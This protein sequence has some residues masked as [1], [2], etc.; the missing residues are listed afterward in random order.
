M[1]REAWLAEGV[2]RGIITEGQRSALEALAAGDRSPDVAGA[3]RASLSPM[4]ATGVMIAY[5]VGAMLALFA[6]GWFV[7]DRWEALGG[8]GLL[9]VATGY[10]LLFLGVARVLAREGYPL[11]HDLAVFLAVAITPLL[12][13]AL[14]VVLGLW[15]DAALR[16]CS[17]LM[18]PAAPCA[19]TPIAL[20]LLT[21]CAAL[22][23]MRRVRFAP[24]AIPGAVAAVALPLELLQAISTHPPT[25]VGNTWAGILSASFALVVAYAVER[26]TTRGE[27]PDYA[28]WMHL[29]AAIAAV[30]ATAQFFGNYA[31]WRHVVP[32]LAL[33]AFVMAVYLR[34]VVWT[35]VGSVITLIYLV[36]LATDVFKL[37]LGFP[38]LLVLLGVVIIIL[39]VWVQKRLPTLVTRDVRDAEG[40]A[41][42]PGGWGVI[43]LPLV[44][45]VVLLA[46]VIPDRVRH[47]VAHPAKVV[48]PHH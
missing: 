4:G 47:E 40:R 19:T 8:V 2:A 37:G 9:L 31:A 5:G 39:T 33:G 34:R 15:S 29:G 45:T 46:T 42:V 25:R 1:Q 3:T 13:W 12:G 44:V 10:L 24:L 18:P 28:F 43:L 22:L 11:A 30:V 38:L 36:W 26:R 17:V 6:M 14:G 21:V 32:F 48:R 27:G 23:A 16:V 41:H 20:Q 7:V 35:V